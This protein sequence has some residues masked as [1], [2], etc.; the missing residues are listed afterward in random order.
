MPS[1]IKLIEQDHREVEELFSQFE[2]S[3]DKSIAMKICAEL[4]AHAE[5]EEKAFYPIVREEVDASLVKEAE[6]EHGEARQLIG[7]I[8]QTSDP[9]HLT[10]LVAELTAHGAEVT[11]RAC[12]VADGGE[13]AALV[14]GVSDAH[15]LTAVVHTAGVLDDGVL[16]SL[17]PERD[18]PRVSGRQGL[19]RL[20]VG[21]RVRVIGVGLWDGRPRP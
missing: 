2:Q 13:V 3:G 5:A 18:R 21:S 15:P 10:E 4:D 8:K 11:V 16:G 9:E 7:R 19:A 20:T 1:I 6:E 17:T 12:D 14:A